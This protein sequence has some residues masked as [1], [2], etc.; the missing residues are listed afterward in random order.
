MNLE[1][2]ENSLTLAFFDLDEDKILSAGKHITDIEDYQ[3]YEFNKKQIIDEVLK[4]L[5]SNNLLKKS[6]TQKDNNWYVKIYKNKEPVLLE[7]RGNIYQVFEKNL[8]PIDESKFFNSVDEA[9]EFINKL[10]NTQFKRLNINICET[11][12]YDSKQTIFTDFNH[13]ETKK[14]LKFLKENNI[15]FK[16][17]EVSVNFIKKLNSYS[18]FKITH[19]SILSGDFSTCNTTWLD[20]DLLDVGITVEDGSFN[21]LHVTNNVIFYNAK[22]NYITIF[23]PLDQYETNVEELELTE[24]EI[25]QIHPK[26]YDGNY[27]VIL[28]GEGEIFGGNFDVFYYDY[29]YG[30]V[31]L[32]NCNINNY[33]YPE[34][35]R[36]PDLSEF[37]GNINNI[38]IDKNTTEI[39]S[40]LF[41]R[42]KNILIS[43]KKIE[44]KEL[45]SYYYKLLENCKQVNKDEFKKLISKKKN[46]NLFL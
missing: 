2:I 14:F 46:Y 28:A 27:K 44:R 15:K 4:K 42:A 11:N 13:P 45:P 43:S 23:A 40:E 10:E 33:F 3:I 21:R 6:I 24:K 19:G 25:E 7:P 39:N 35:T 38:V 9:K 16:D 26:I 41:N 12:D 22:A 18:N 32:Y 29:E 8:K 17:A 34:E 20:N 5:S 30:S 31:K 1:F 36:L 37:T